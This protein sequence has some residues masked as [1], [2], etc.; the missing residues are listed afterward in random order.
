MAETW[1]QY[2]AREAVFKALERIEHG[3]LTVV[4]T[5]GSQKGFTKQFGNDDNDTPNATIM[6][7]S[8]K[9]WERICNQFDLV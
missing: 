6:F 7:N 4:T 9:V 5:Y 8:P 3:K 1:R 2:Y